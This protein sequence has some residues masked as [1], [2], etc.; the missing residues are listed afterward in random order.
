MSATFLSKNLSRN[1]LE[2]EVIREIN[3]S[4]TDATTSVNTP[5]QVGQASATTSTSVSAT[6]F[7]TLTYNYTAPYIEAPE[8]IIFNIQYTESQ[9]PITNLN[10]LC[11]LGSITTTGFTIY[12]QN[13]SSTDSATIPY[14][15]YSAYGGIL[16]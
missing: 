11:V 2:A 6:T 16:A 1:L 4:K 5:T 9:L 14:I 13:N 8:Y 7:V 10:F 15:Q 3:N 12:M